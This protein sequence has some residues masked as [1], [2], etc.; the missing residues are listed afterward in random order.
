[1]ATNQVDLAQL[2]GTVAQ[3]LSENKSALNAADTYNNDHGDNMV[4]IFNLIA[5][6]VQENKGA[7]P[8][9]QLKAAA[10]KI[11]KTKSG[12]AQLYAKGLAQAAKEFKDKALTPQNIALLAQVL[13][14][15]GKKTTA[16]S[17]DPLNSI[18]T[19]L[20]GNQ[21]QSSGGDG[22]DAGDLL[23]AGMTFLAAKQSGDDNM[24]ALVRTLVSN[25][26]MSSAPHR[27]ESGQV[28]V[29]TLLNAMLSMANKG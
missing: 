13:L 15:G 9:A 19:G 29:N 2:F 26:A 5:Q 4:Q 11:G 16:Q 14:A 28:V 18:L 12:S 10:T 25:S 21:Q 8:S 22:M 3:A 7:K 1:M 20:L 27:E 24:N 23:N 17:N 6:A